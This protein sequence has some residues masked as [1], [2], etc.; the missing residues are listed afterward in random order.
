[1]MRRHAI[2]LLEFRM[3]AP[4]LLSE[5]GIFLSPRVANSPRKAPLVASTTHET[6]HQQATL[7]PIIAAGNDMTPPGPKLGAAW[8]ATVRPLG[9]HDCCQPEHRRWGRGAGLRLGQGVAQSCL[10]TWSPVRWAL[11]HP[12]SAPI[13]FGHA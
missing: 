8:P 7:V 5:H 13:I 6:S 1:M 11:V 4:F 9:C 12:L 10:H 2:T 3:A